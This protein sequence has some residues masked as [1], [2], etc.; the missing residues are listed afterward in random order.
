MAVLT[1]LALPTHALATAPLRFHFNFSDT[2]QDVDVCGISVDVVSEGVVTDQLFF[3][4]NG[5][6]GRFMSTGSGTTRFTADN[7]KSVVVEFA[8]LFVD[9]GAVIDEAAG[10]ITFSSTNIGLPEKIQASRGPVLLRDAGTIS[11]ISIFDLATFEPISF[12]VVSH[13]PHPEADSDFTL[14]CEVIAAAL[15]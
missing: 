3:D 9:Q 1:V 5:D 13:G 11:F 6:I 14:F 4:T 8:G 12:D 15:T 10:T 7:G 2:A